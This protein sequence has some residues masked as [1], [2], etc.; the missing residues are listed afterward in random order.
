M[1]GT[2]QLSPLLCSILAWGEIHPG[3]RA[4]KIQVHL[5]LGKGRYTML[6][7]HSGAFSS[8]V[9]R[10]AGRGFLEEVTCS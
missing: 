7:K 1:L 4:D 6:Q 8:M 5:R 3:G 10:A 9:M 2:K